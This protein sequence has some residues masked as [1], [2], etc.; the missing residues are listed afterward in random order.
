MKVLF[1]SRL[2]LMTRPGGD[3]TQIILTKEALERLYSDV[4]IEINCEINPTNIDNYDIVHLFNLDWVCETYPQAVWAKKHKKPLVLSAIHHSEKEVLRYEKEYR[5]DYRRV[6]NEIIPSQPLR[7]MLKNIYRAV[8]NDKRKIRPTILQLIKGIR[9]QQREILSLSD[10]VLVQTILEAEDIQKDLGSV[11]F[12]WRKVINGVNVKKFT[13]AKPDLFKKYM[14]ERKFRATKIILNVGR[15]EPRKNLL[16]IIKAFLELKEENNEYNDFKLVIISEKNKRSP[17]Y[18]YGFERYL[19]KYPNDIIYCG[20]QEQD[21]IASAMKYEGIFI[22]ASWFETS[23][24]VALE[25]AVAGMVPIVTGDRA[26]EYLGNNAV[27]CDPGSIQDIKDAILKASHMKRLDNAVIN[28][29]SAKYN[30]DET[31]KQT[32]QVYKDILS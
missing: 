24:L 8:F 30:W 17:E 27:Y 10:I 23:G 29:L 11:D 19:K 5:F 21:F 2:D 28:E 15:I 12:K 14:S 13:E 7:D 25:S 6:V 1:Q 9:N 31:A 18:L 32:Y 20:R 22:N 16:S 3:R 26:K 4:H